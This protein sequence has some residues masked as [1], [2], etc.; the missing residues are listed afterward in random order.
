MSA[1][2]PVF[3]D[4]CERVSACLLPGLPV[5]QPILIS[6][7]ALITTA[8]VSDCLPGHLSLYLPSSYLCAC[9]CLPGHIFF[10]SMPYLPSCVSVSSTTHFSMLCLPGHFSLF[11]IPSFL[12]VYVFQD[13]FLSLCLPSP[14]SM[15]YLPSSVSTRT[16]FSLSVLTIASPV[17]LSVVSTRTP[18]S[19]CAY[20]RLSRLPVSCVCRQ[21]CVRAWW[22]E[23]CGEER[24]GQCGV[25][26]R[27]NG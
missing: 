19:L 12:C 26:G 22:G 15:L 17:S 16:P 7:G 24:A 20:H 9:L 10:L 8:S 4:V 6:L 23:L 11:T 5:F 2:L 27:G 18:F 1:S 25:S 3:E 14:F 21:P 13:S